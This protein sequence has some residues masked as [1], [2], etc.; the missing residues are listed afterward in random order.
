MNNLI[1]N[2][3]EQLIIETKQSL[4]NIKRVSLNE[5][6]KI[7]QV[8]VA[9]VVQLLE[10]SANEL[11]GPDKKALAMMLLNNFYDAVFV[12][13]DIPFVPSVLEPIIHKQVKNILMVFVSASID[14]T[15]TI[16]RKTGIFL[17]KGSKNELQ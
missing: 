13:I 12:I 11:S 8:T 9:Y 1:N 14:A 3:I 2:K 4:D 7:L 10:N 5:A 16:F 6:W 15:V 17:T